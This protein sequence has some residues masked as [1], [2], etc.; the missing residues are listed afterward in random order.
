M[1]ES[2][3]IKRLDIGE[4]EKILPFLLRSRSSLLYASPSFM[5]LVTQHLGAQGGW[6]AAYEDEEITALLPFAV[7]DGPLGPV[8]NSLAYYGSNGGVIQADHD[9]DNAVKAALINSYYQRAADDKALAATIITN[10]LLQDFAFYQNHITSD[11]YDERIGQITHFPAEPDDE[12]LMAL[13][14]DPR[15]RNIRKAQRAGIT[16]EKRHDEAALAFLYETHE[17]NMSAI[18]GLAKRRDF[19]DLVPQIMDQKDW[20]IYVASLNGQPIAALLLFYFNRTV[21]YFTP[22]II[23]EFRNMQALALIIYRAMNDAR[24]DGFENWNWG[25]TWLSQGGVYDFKK[26]WG[27]RDYPYYYYTKIFNRDVYDQSRDDLLKHYE[28]F[29]VLP[30]AALENKKQEQSA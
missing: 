1:S 13:F 22:V 21:E 6:L 10:P 29:Y 26:R 16:I 18:G 4:G 25:G 23:E 17:Q 30:F 5:K 24:H 27:T 8:Y 2:A 28:G 3:S 12:A 20:A 9:N 11:H 19:F 14:D 15:P 7:K